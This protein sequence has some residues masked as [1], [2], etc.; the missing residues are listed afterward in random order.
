MAAG[1]FAQKTRQTFGSVLTICVHHDHGVIACGLMNV[2]Q[3]NSDCA[4]VAKIAPQTQRSYRTYD[5][6]I[7]LKIVRT[8]SQ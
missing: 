6:E 2:N 4:L 3:P 7:A 8:P 1:V 5:G